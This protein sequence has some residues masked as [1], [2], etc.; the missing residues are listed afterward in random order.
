[1]SERLVFALRALASATLLTLCALVMLIVAALTLFR[2]R[3]LYADRVML[4][5][6]R[7][8]LRIWKLRLEVIHEAP[9]PAVQTVYV[10]N[11]SS[12]IDLFALVA[13]GLPN[14]R[15]FLSGA[16][17][18]ILPLGL[19]GYLIG[20]FWT[21]D[22]S[23]P[24]ARVRIFQRACRILQRTGES[25]C[26][27]PEGRRVTTGEIGPFNKGAFH[28]AA[29]LQA[30]MQP[31]FIQIPRHID[32]GRGLHARPGTV[33]VHVGV[34]IDTRSWRPQDAAVRKEEVR[35]H[36]QRWKARLDA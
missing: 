11:H 29:A 32:P 22:Q 21:V 20:I 23:R 13:L 35:A 17:R 8:F 6:G 1:M 10:M 28:L 12:T 4:P 30:P 9:F 5:C 31:L 2:C 7:L 33:R 27:S 3:R 19:I 36:Y 14:T 25:V 15:F 34:P 16:L 24:E 26:L 18:R